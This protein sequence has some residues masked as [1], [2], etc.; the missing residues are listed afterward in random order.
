[1]LYLCRPGVLS[2]DKDYQKHLADIYLSRSHSILN[3]YL[4]LL[5]LDCPV[6][7]SWLFVHITLSCALSLGVTATES[8]DAHDRAS[9]KR[10]VDILST[11]TICANVSAYE[12]AL[13]HLQ[14]FVKAHE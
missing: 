10:F 2:L 13:N 4:E 12:I 8:G 14:R 6:R 11:T 7:R 1:M 5:R 9:L 3:I